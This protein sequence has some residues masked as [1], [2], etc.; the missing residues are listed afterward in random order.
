MS[1]NHKH[2]PVKKKGKYFCFKCKKEL[3][4]ISIDID[5][6]LVYGI[7]ALFTLLILTIHGLIYK[8]VLLLIWV[9]GAFLISKLIPSKKKW[10]LKWV[11]VL[12]LVRKKNGK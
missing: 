3:E 10:V 5:Y 2:D 7:I 9:T 1:K 8:S 6:E 11:D 12:E 4:K